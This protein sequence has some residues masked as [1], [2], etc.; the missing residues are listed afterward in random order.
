MHSANLSTFQKTARLRTTYTQIKKNLT[1]NIDKWRD[2]IPHGESQF[3]DLN[4]TRKLAYERKKVALDQLPHLLEQFEK[5][6][7]N[8]GC[9]VLW[10]RNTKDALRTIFSICKQE[11]CDTVVKSKSMATEEIHLNKYLF[12]KG[13]T[14]FE[15]DLGEFI[16]QIAG[17]P[18]IH[19][20]TPAMHR[21]KEEVAQLFHRHLCVDPNLNPDQLTK[22][23]RNYLRKQ[24]KAAQIGI[25]GAN[26][27]LPDIGGVAITENEGNARL[28]FGLP[29][30]HIVIVGIE[31]MLPSA[32]DLSL[33]WPLLATYGTGQ[34][35]TSYNT[36]ITG[37]K[38]SGEMDG[39]EKMYIILLD[40]GRTDIYKNPTVRESLYCI[41]CGSCLNVC[42]VYRNLAGGHAYHT[43]YT[44]P[45]GS[46]ISPHLH[47]MHRYGHLPFASSLCG[48]CTEICPVNIPLHQLLLVNREQMVEQQQSSFLESMIWSVFTFVMCR[49]NLYRLFLS[50]FKVL[51]AHVLLRPWN[52][53]H[54]PIPFAR[55]TFHDLY[56]AHSKS[57]SVK[58]AAP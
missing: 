56:R 6:A 16:Q 11:K 30:T 5:N 18:P 49:P 21:S 41:R 45:I 14:V 39:P 13:I 9:K 38:K 36:I 10:T 48:A 25:T 54:S 55:K 28:V 4:E 2:G 43:T 46:V 57:R 33:F 51:T 23:A 31:K 26:F 27:L 50:P 52:K 47:G 35:I 32:A 12:Q 34:Y 42:P 22:I 20:L 15:T 29:R 37:P 1:H 7:T 19:I 44:G 58:K 3:R 17:E 24:F 8:N 53:I 40:N